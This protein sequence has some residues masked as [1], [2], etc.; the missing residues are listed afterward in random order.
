MTFKPTPTRNTT[1][2]WTREKQW[3]F[4]NHLSAFGS[5]SAAARA[6]GMTDRS[7][8][9]LRARVGGEAFREAWDLALYNAGGQ[10]LAVAV[11]RALNGSKR[12]YI[13][14]GKLI[15]EQIA[16]SDRLLMWTVERLHPRNFG[17]RT[18]AN[19]VMDTLQRFQDWGPERIYA[20]ENEGQALPEQQQRLAAE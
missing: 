17:R 16:P 9:K 6:V 7:A 5:V 3:D 11:D 10:L 19:D 15:G 2:G 8:Y 1:A 4:I 20:D 12:Q 14:D 13:K 18:T